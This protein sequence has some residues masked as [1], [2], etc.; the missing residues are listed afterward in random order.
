MLTTSLIVEW[1]G[2][3]ALEPIENVATEDPSVTVK[4]HTKRAEKLAGKA[5][6]QLE[7]SESERKPRPQHRPSPPELSES[8]DD[9]SGDEYVDEGDRREDAGAAGG[10]THKRMVRHQV[11]S[12]RAVSIPAGAGEAGTTCSRH[13]TTHN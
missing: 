7:E 6:E 11:E 3:D 13:H 5:Q 2:F 9:E 8:S 1:E 12:C 10:N 4:T